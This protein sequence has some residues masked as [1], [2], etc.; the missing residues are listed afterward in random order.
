VAWGALLLGIGIGLVMGG[1][2]AGL[3]GFA[4]GKALH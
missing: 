4:L 1:T 2:V 3:L